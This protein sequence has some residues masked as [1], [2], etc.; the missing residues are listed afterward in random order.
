M[1]KIIVFFGIFI[2]SC[3][4]HSNKSVKNNDEKD[5]LFLELERDMLYLKNL[6]Y[7]SY[8]GRLEISTLKNYHIDFKT[9]SCYIKTNIKDVSSMHYV[10]SGNISLRYLFEDQNREKL[11]KKWLEKEFELIPLEGGEKIKHSYDFYKALEFY[12][13][14][15]LK[16][17][18]DSVRS[19]EMKKMD[20]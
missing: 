7:I 15:D 13:S 17:Y 6:T 12:N 19:V 3:N 10:Q 14:E 9:D 2:L 1:K 18:I 5:S 11:L 4:Y 20:N 8:L 16:K